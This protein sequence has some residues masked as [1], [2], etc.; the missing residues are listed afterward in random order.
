MV[1]VACLWTNDCS[2]RAGLKDVGL[3]SMIAGMAKY[4]SRDYTE[5][6]NQ[7]VRSILQRIE[8]A[9]DKRLRSCTESFSEL[10]FLMLIAYQLEDLIPYTAEN[11]HFSSDK[12]GVEVGD[13]F[14]FGAAAVMAAQ[15][16]GLSI[17]AVADLAGLDG[18][19]SSE[20]DWDIADLDELDAWDASEQGVSADQFWLV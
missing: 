10:G 16:D 13:T 15:D 6:A 1:D 3:M 17:G 5:M 18:A 8:P 4:T 12:L 2:I 11:I 19:S 7:N 14:E 20:E 9:M